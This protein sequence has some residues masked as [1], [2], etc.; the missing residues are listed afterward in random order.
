MFDDQMLREKCVQL[1]C[2]SDYNNKMK[3]IH[4]INMRIIILF[5]GK[6]LRGTAREQIGPPARTGALQ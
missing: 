1:H 3:T 4:T 6:F 2:S 5:F